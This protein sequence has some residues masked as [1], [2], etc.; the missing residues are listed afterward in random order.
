MASTVANI[1][2][3]RHKNIISGPPTLSVIEALKIMNDRNIGSL[4]IIDGDYYKG[5]FTERDYARKVA[6]KGRRSVDTTVAEVMSVD[7]PRV[8]PRDR[9]EHCMKLM[10]DKNVRYLPVMEQH[11]LVGI[12]SILD[13]IE[14]TVSVQSETISHL[15]DYMQGGY[16]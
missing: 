12:I 10:S 7:L 2:R 14:E 1:L 16:A 5:I 6:L 15:R 9:I 4:V 8:S 13:L 11:R 3:K